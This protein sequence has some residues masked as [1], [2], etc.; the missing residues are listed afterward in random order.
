[1][2]N[3]LLCYAVA[4]NEMLMLTLIISYEESIIKPQSISI[5]SVEQLKYH[6][7]V[8]TV[9]YTFVKNFSINERIN[10]NTRSYSNAIK[11]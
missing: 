4:F 11:N 7:K 9:C 3:V 5:I 10:K 6:V 2:N 8:D 1:M